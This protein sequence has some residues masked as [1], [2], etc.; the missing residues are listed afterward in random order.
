MDALVALA[1]PL[2]YR[3]RMSTVQQSLD[4]AGCD[5]LLVSSLTNIRYLTGFT[6]SSAL[7][8][9]RADHALFVTDFRYGEQA[10]EQLGRAAIDVDLAVDTAP[11]DPVVT[12]VTH[13]R[14]VG[15]E[16]SHV[17]WAQQRAYRKDWFP[18]K[19]LTPT[20]GVVETLRVKKEL[21]ERARIEAAATIADQ[22]LAACLPR[23]GDRPTEAEFAGE[24]DAMAR[25]FG[26]Y[27]PAF[28]TIIASGPNSARPHARPGSRRMQDGDLVV[29]DFGATLD[30]YRSDMTRT[31]CLGSPNVQQQEIYDVVA[32]AKA[33]GAL[34]TCGGV[35]ALDVDTAARTVIEEAGWGPQFGHGTGHGVGLDIHEAPHIGRTSTATLVTGAVVTVEPGIYVVGVGGVRLEDSVVVQEDGCVALTRSP[36]ILAL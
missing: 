7:L 14:Q 31:F 30:G 4:K 25:S 3:S 33:A 16:A 11:K 1:I 5:A 24:L 36:F 10:T 22:A 18:D 34:K 20:E 8:V 29:V 2:D 28:E 26:S 17:T 35:A 27:G 21:G 12:F 32:A 19:E 23:L 13:C 9:L 6:G 15:L